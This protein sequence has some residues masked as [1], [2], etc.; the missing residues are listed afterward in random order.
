MAKAPRG[1][2]IRIDSTATVSTRLPQARPM[3]RGMGPIAA[4]T[5][6][7]GQ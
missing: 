3:L 2:V 6:A 1:A 4:C 5:V 7:L